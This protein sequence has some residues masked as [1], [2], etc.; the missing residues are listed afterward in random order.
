MAARAHRPAPPLSFL[1][2]HDEEEGS[3]YVRPHRPPPRS[4]PALA[5]DVPEVI[6]H[7]NTFIPNTGK[8]TPAVAMHY[9]GSFN[10]YCTAH[11]NRAPYSSGAEYVYDSYVNGATSISYRSVYRVVCKKPHQFTRDLTQ[12]DMGY[13]LFRQEYTVDE[14]T[15]MM[16]V[17]KQLQGFASAPDVDDAQLNNDRQLFMTA[18]DQQ[19]TLSMPVNIID[20]DVVTS[21][22]SKIAEWNV[23][24]NPLEAARADMTV[25]DFVH[26]ATIAGATVK[27]IVEVLQRVPAGYHRVMLA[28]MESNSQFTS[29]V[30][31]EEKIGGESFFFEHE[32][33]PTQQKMSSHR[34]Q[35][36]L[37]RR[38]VSLDAIETFRDHHIENLHD[39][40]IVFN[41]DHKRAQ[42]HLPQTDRMV[43][44]I[45]E[46][47]PDE[48]RRDR[49]FGGAVLLES[50]PG[51]KRQAMHC[52]Y[53]PD[54][55]RSCEIKPLGVLVALEEGAHLVLPDRVI[56]MRVG[57][58]LV[59]EGD[60]PHAGGAYTTLNRRVHIYLDGPVACR[61]PNKTYLA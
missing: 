18:L 37:L 43:A 8:S 34:Q 31:V 12:W 29:D 44:H 32:T 39:F 45:L 46:L 48:L 47:L 49:V 58:I 33:H 22:E 7:Q 20:E 23:Q 15:S 55:V 60:M 61:K 17:T 40:Y 4:P 26:L 13:E 21:I 27:H 53:D 1:D 41:P 28:F 3:A 50:Q 54:L 16:T 11:T 36:Q 14:T 25:I 6:D 2:R 9:L 57:D 59:F 35:W 19:G 56:N 42:C 5:V 51:C 52:D 10:K 38:R 24:A 30:S